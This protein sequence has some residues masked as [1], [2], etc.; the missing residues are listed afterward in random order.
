MESMIYGLNGHDA[1]N[2]VQQMSTLGMKFTEEQ[3]QELLCGRI[4][5]TGGIF[6]KNGMENGWGRIIVSRMKCKKK[7]AVL[8]RNVQVSICLKISCI[9]N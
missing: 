6:A 5:R 8:T 9:K 1:Q 3:D 7:N 2:P 4:Q